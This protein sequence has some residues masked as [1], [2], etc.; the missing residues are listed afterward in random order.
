MAPRNSVLSVLGLVPEAKMPSERSAP[1][2]HDS[3]GEV[4]DLRREVKLTIEHNQVSVMNAMRDV[5]AEFTRN[6][7]R[8]ESGSDEG[9][10][11]LGKNPR[12]IVPAAV[13]ETPAAAVSMARDIAAEQETNLRE[14]ASPDL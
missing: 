9:S 7:G 2:E 3:T 1:D 14:G 11:A 6:N 13:R 12:G 10:A 8:S 5:M 4:Q